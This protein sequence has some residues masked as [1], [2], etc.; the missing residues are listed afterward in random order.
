[1]S[2]PKVQTQTRRAKAKPLSD[3]KRRKMVRHIIET[4]LQSEFGF[5]LQPSPLKPEPTRKKR[6]RK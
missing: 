6:R 1:M 4:G 5:A 2:A 3:E